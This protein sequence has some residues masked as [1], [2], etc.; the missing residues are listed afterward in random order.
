MLNKS[1]RYILN[2]LIKYILFNNVL[3]FNNLKYT[4]YSISMI[5]IINSSNGLIRSITI[6]KILILTIWTLYW[7]SLLF[8]LDWIGIGYNLPSHN[9]LKGFIKVIWLL[10][11]ERML[12]IPFNIFLKRLIVIKGL[13]LLSP[14]VR[15]VHENKKDIY[16]QN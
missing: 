6:L 9:F 1:N 8:K 4:Q 5:K 10:L 3:I 13:H 15:E 11:I 7:K 12:L 16:C 14:E 2:I